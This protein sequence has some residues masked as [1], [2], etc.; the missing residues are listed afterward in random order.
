MSSAPAID[1]ITFEVVRNKLGAITEEQAI[2]LK[3]VS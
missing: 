1:P 2:T 3:S